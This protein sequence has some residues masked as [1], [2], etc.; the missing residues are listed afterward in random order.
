MQRA[1]RHSQ[2][3]RGTVLE[4]SAGV[5]C[6]QIFLRI[7]RGTMQNYGNTSKHLHFVIA[8]PVSQ[9]FYIAL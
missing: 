4:S 7:S 1:H 5:L 6:F 2:N 9:I 3:P 8:A